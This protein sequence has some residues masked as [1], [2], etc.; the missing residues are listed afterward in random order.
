MNVIWALQARIDLAQ[1]RAYYVRLNP[2]AA[3]KLVDAII[4]AAMQLED[5]PQLGRGSDDG[6]IRLWQVVGLPYLLP[7]RHVGK[8]LEILAVFDERQK[9][10]DEWT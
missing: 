5:F 7:Y 4:A 6:K 9:R 2:T 10:P 8:D 1:I 3:E